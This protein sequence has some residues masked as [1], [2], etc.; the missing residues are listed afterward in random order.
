M[1]QSNNVY[2]NYIHFIKLIDNS[3]KEGKSYRF[4][5]NGIEQL[6]IIEII[7]DKTQGDEPQKIFESLNSTG[8]ELTLSDLIRNYLLID[9]KEQDE[10]YFDYWLEM[11]KNVGYEELG[12]LFI[13]FLKAHMSATINSK[14]A[15]QYFKEYCQMNNLENK[16]V[17]EHLKRTSKY[18][19]TFLGNEQFYSST[20]TQI[21]QAFHKIKQ[22]TVL[23]VLFQLLD[24]FEEKKISENELCSVLKYL[25]TYYIRM[26][27]CEKTKGLNRFM[28]SLYSRAMGINKDSY[29]DKFITLFNHSKVSARMPT[30]KEFRDALI[31]KPMY[32][33][34]ITRYMLEMIENSNKEQ[35]KF[36]NFTIEHILPQKENATVWRNEIGKDY[37]RIYEI[38]L[39]TLGNLTVTGYNSELGTKS[40]EA[41]KEIIKKYSKAVVLNREVLSAKEWNEDSIVQRANILAKEIIELFP[42][43]E[44]EKE[45]ITKDELCFALSEDINY[46]GLKPKGLIYQREYLK[47][48]TWANLLSSFIE[49]SYELYP[50]QIT[51]LAEN[52]FILNN[53]KRVYMST[54]Q[55]KFR[56]HRQVENTKVFYETNLSANNIIS[57][58]RQVVMELKLD[59]DE[60][61]IY[62]SNLPFNL[63]N[64]NT[65]D[66]ENI[67]V[68][69]LLYEFIKDLVQ[70]DRLS[71][72]DIQELQ[73]SRYSSQI[74][75]NTVYPILTTDPQDY[76][77]ED[78]KNIYRSSTIKYD[79]NDYYVLSNIQETDRKSIIEWYAMH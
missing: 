36:D 34:N 16:K 4:I 13:N 55:S 5:L 75:S 38:Y 7:L 8:L 28:N 69:N 26:I 31:Y 25:L 64:S 76:I 32:K 15:Y 2:K 1:N 29:L 45:D 24:D 71:Q 47:A 48:S 63:K 61:Y 37:D 10:L 73:K 20:V 50:K 21:L 60:F 33:K 42:Y 62:L 77:C 78:H 65:W 35:V 30:D 72:K 43:Q 6:E 12:S 52:N 22:N 57:F 54:D 66:K 67:T 70:R 39:H 68:N 56:V 74:V 79:K 51:E 19:A 3:I 58:I 14:N 46:A 59:V 53:A 49:L 44:I 40:F 27:T 17:L 18:Y 23:P 41:K 9:E 11:E